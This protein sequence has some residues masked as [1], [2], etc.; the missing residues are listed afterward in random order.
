MVALSSPSAAIAA[1]V[2]PSIVAAAGAR[3]VD[4]WFAGPWA[5]EERERAGKISTEA[6]QSIP[7][8]FPHGRSLGHRLFWMPRKPA[9]IL[10]VFRM[11]WKRRLPDALH[12]KHC[13]R[14][15]RRFR[16]TASFLRCLDVGLHA[17]RHQPLAVAPH[18]DPGGA[19]GRTGI[20]RHHLRRDHRGGIAVNRKAHGLYFADR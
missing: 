4:C 3:P 11:D 6:A 1:A 15:A 18:P 17:D 5:I 16:L 8:D 12:T 10:G 7:R 9:K 13:V 14:L 2:A 19:I 20:V